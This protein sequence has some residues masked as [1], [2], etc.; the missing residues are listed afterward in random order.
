MAFPEGPVQ[1]SC[2]A[3]NSTPITV[4]ALQPMSWVKSFVVISAG[5]HVYVVITGVGTI[6]SDTKK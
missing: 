6:G 4:V 3:F 5:V 2:I 1:L